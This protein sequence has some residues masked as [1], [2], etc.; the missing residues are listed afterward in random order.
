MFSYITGHDP[1]TGKPIRKSVYAQTQRE[2]RRR[3]AQA[4]ADID[5]NGK[6]LCQRSV[7][8][9]DGFGGHGSRVI[10]G[11]SILLDDLPGDSGH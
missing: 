11:F 8:I 10:Y 3:L 2:V 7:D 1:G 6:G 9:A 4:I 5:S